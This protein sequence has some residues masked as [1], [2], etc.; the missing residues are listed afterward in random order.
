MCNAEYH[1]R[2]RCTQDSAFLSAVSACSV[3]NHPG[4]RRRGP[5]YRQPEFV[6]TAA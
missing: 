2:M 4:E 6:R 3:V 1:P 5:I